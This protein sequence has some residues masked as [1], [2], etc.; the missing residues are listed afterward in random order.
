MSQGSF[1][2]WTAELGF[3][4]RA[5]GP[6][7]S[8]LHIT[9]RSWTLETHKGTQAVDEAVALTHSRTSLPALFLFWCLQMA[10]MSLHNNVKLTALKNFSQHSNMK[11]AQANCNPSSWSSGESEDTF[12][13]WALCYKAGCDEL[14]TPTLTNSLPA[15]VF[16]QSSYE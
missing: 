2:L 15:L 16:L 13:A 1:S 4:R 10:S 6:R 3:D 5:I 12:L 11:G 8:S 9:L 7:A 14:Q